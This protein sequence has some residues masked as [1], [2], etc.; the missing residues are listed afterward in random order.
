MV[1]VYRF[2]QHSTKDIER[3]IARKMDYP[4]GS[5]SI[6]LHMMITVR[7]KHSCLHLQ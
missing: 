1:D 7:F 4:G 2:V 6:S 3:R 5:S